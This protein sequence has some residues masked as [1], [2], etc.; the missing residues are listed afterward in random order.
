MARVL[1]VDDAPD[2]TYLVSTLLQ[3]QGHEVESV[4]NGEEALAAIARDAPDLVVTDLQMPVMNGLEL[5]QAVAGSHPCL[6]IVLIT[7]YGSEE[8]AVQALQRG[9][10]SYIPKR[11][12]RDELIDTVH[13]LLA[14][15]QAKRERSCVLKSLTHSSFEFELPNDIG[16]IP[17]LIAYMEEILA[18]RFGH[19]EDGPVFHAGVALSEA[20]MNAIHHGNLEVDSELRESDP[21]EYQRLVRER[22]NVLPYRDRL[23]QVHAAISSHEVRYTVRDQGPGFAHAELPDPMN[24]ANLLRLSGRGLF[25]I[26]T[27]MDSVVFNATGNEIT[28]VKRFPA[29]PSPAH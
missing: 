6:P 23:V 18:A 10:A 17:P 25:L 11:R 22:L 29:T 14:P 20:V 24:A 26:R 1:V 16:L 13:N 15:D 28:M 4:V 7:A 9:A 8:V 27:F 2:Q 3:R 21:S 19:E 5:V 12:L